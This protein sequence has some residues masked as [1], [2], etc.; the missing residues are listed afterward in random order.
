M[1]NESNSRSAAW[2]N[3]RLWLAGGFLFALLIFFVNLGDGGIYAAQEGR[4]A[5][6]TRNMLLSGNW[7]D[8]QIPH[9]IAYE[10]P[11]GHYWL[12]AP[13]A[14]C[15]GLTGE[16]GLVPSEWAVRLPSALSGLLA[17][18]A[19]ALLA[20][21]IYGVRTAAVSMVVLSSMATFAN[22]GRLAHID[23]PLACSFVWAMYFLYIG[24]FEHNRGNA[25]LYAFYAMLGWGTLLK[26]PVVLA[27]A[28]LTVLCVAVHRRNWKLI[29][30]MR[31]F[32][33]VLVYL[34]VT[35]PWYAAESVRSNG[36]FFREFIVNQNLR[37]FTGIGSTYRD[38]ERMPIY[39]Y[40]PK[41]L[42]G[43][44]PWSLAGI[45]AIAVYF[46]RLVRLQFRPATL[47]LLFWAVGSF[48]FFS[49][50]ALKRGDYL[51]PI[52]P[53]LAILT[54]RAVV[55]FCERAP[56]LHRSWRWVWLGC[57]GV[58]GAAA[59]LNRSGILIRLGERIAAGEISFISKRDGMN[60]TAI[61]SFIN[62]NFPLFLLLAL[63]ALALLR[64]IGV[65]LEKRR[66]WSAFAA[67]AAIVCGLF[68]TYHA[69]IQPGT[70]RL[71]TVKPFAEQVRAIVPPGEEVVYQY[72]FNTELIYFVNRPY[73]IRL[74]EGDRYL[75]TNRSG[76][77][78]FRKLPESSHWH[79]LCSTPEGHTYSAVLLERQ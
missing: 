32:T 70:D 71:N 19:A 11:I 57:A 40:F 46:R 37:R 49:L 6:I 31:P 79:E 20:H 76:V 67:A 3:P 66:C 44:L 10:K 42:A 60:L 38:G 36:E 72:D 9:A 69:V 53:A 74:Q 29:W 43:A 12:C 27:W 24:C 56:E 8:M 47:F 68:T 5:I 45:A 18:I 64:T 55:L 30:E 15:F 41:L 52:Y 73:H 21:R 65:L 51:L 62:D 78:K 33:G 23:M 1:E 22:L 4:T 25:W 39:Y 50:S 17:V 54:A 14:Y 77:R 13:F 34:A 58:L 7:L 61:S 28:G 16:P 63:L 75:L 48:I 2:N 59:L 26:G 35:L